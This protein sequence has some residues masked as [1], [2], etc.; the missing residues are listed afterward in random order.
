MTAVAPALLLHEARAYPLPLEGKLTSRGL[1]YGHSLRIAGRNFGVGFAENAR[2]V[3]GGPL[4]PVQGYLYQHATVISA[5]PIPEERVEAAIDDIIIESGRV[6]RIVRG[7]TWGRPRHWS[8]SDVLTL[9]PAN[10]WLSYYS[11]ANEDGSWSVYGELFLSA[12]DEGEPVEG[13]Q[14]LVAQAANEAE[15]AAIENALQ[16]AA[17]NYGRTD[18]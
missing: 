12:D 17:N 9:E 15:A 4:V 5:H 2:E 11:S 18:V 13:S 7:V 8:S 1:A 16:V 10:L 3:E 14:F 6:W